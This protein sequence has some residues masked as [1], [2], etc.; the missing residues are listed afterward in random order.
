MKPT[1][2]RIASP[3]G[4]R[5]VPSTTP[6]ATCSTSGPVIASV[7]AARRPGVSGSHWPQWQSL[8][9]APNSTPGNR[10]RQYAMIAAP[11]PDHRRQVWQHR[12]MVGLDVGCGAGRRSVLAGRS[13]S[14]PARGAGFFRFA[15]ARVAR[16]PSYPYFPP[17]PPLAGRTVPKQAKMGVCAGTWGKKR[18][19]RERVVFIVL[20][21]KTYRQ[22]S[23]TFPPLLSPTCSKSP[24]TQSPFF[25]PVR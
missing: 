18:R 6:P 7:G 14:R 8:P 15:R 17:S 2:Y 3:A 4:A 22:T 24:W 1:P 9:V 19:K 25:H 5:S 23:F 21:T 11:A 10:T 16:H 20:F 12:V 13:Q